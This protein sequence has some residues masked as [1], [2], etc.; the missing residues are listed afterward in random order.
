MGWHDFR[1][2]CE[3]YGLE[4]QW[5]VQ[6]HCYKIYVWSWKSPYLGIRPLGYVTVEQLQDWEVDRIEELVVSCS[7]DALMG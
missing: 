3:K 7:I 4:L 5:D 6:R 2:L 1:S